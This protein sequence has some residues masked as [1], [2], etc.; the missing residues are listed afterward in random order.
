MQWL[1]GRESSNVEDQRGSGGGYGGGGGFRIP[2]GGR[3]GIGIVGLLVVGAISLFF[4]VDPSVILNG[5]DPGP[6]SYQADR[7]SAQPSG[8]G[9]E[10][11][12]FVS[13]V[14]AD[15]EDT[16]GQVFAAQGRQ[17]EQPRLVLFSDAVGSACGYAQS[18]TGPF[19]CPADH[20]V[21]LDLSFF[22]E[23][24]DRFGAPG[25][26][27][28][29]YVIAHE[30]GHHLQVLLGIEPKVRSAMSRASKAETNALSVRMELQA[31]CFAGA[32]GFHARQRGILEQGDLEEAL[33]AATAI[34]DDR[35]Q[36]RSQG[37]VVPESFTHGSSAQRVRWFK[38]G[39]ERGDL[40]ACDT[41]SAQQL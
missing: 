22:R 31:D 38:R 15:T 26:F 3:G 29:A 32:W 37:R 21:Y 28:Q 30:V 8:Q 36:S 33:N 40:N 27:A 9:D 17:Y 18:A 16:W 39:F 10:V 34:G 4:G 7:R 19:Y 2:I 35:L 14:L 25:D 5:G 6:S 1:G 11:K 13:V 41:F 12:R 23:L 20:K 24:R